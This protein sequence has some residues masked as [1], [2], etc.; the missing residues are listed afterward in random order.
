MRYDNGRYLDGWYNR[1]RDA[2][3]ATMADLG[4]PADASPEEFL[5]AMDGYRQRDPENAC[6]LKAPRPRMDG[7][8]FRSARAA[9]RLCVPCPPRA[10]PA[11]SNALAHQM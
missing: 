1:L 4:V 5:T 8:A 10:Q 7:R 3:I 2:Y 11:K 9:A 6:L